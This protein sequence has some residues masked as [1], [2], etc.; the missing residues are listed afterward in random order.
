MKRSGAIANQP[1][2]GVDVIALV[3]EWREPHGDA[4]LRLSKQFQLV[5]CPPDV[6]LV[7]EM[8]INRRPRWLVVCDARCND[9]PLALVHAGRAMSPGLRVAVL[10]SAHDIEA[11][12]R[13]IRRGCDIYLDTHRS[14]E[15]L[16]YCIRFAE[17]SNVVVIDRDVSRAAQTMQVQPL[18][19]L[20]R[21]ERD[22]LRHLRQGL[23]NADIA[24]ELEVT[25]G[26]VEFHV[27]RLLSKLGARNRVEAIGH[28]HALGL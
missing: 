22:V 18:G 24:Q 27:S 14:L 3:G 7:K 2:T 13:W 21:R 25:E 12:D 9:E 8:V 6:R 17:D 16:L 26:T 23:R 15:C 1:F 10:G 20:T 19:A 11:C 28:A 5:T 4:A